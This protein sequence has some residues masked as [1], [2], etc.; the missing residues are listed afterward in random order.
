MDLEIRVYLVYSSYLLMLRKALIIQT[1]IRCMQDD[2]GIDVVSVLK[3]LSDPQKISILRELGKEEEGLSFSLTIGLILI[4]AESSQQAVKSGDDS[5]KGEDKK[6][7]RLSLEEL[8]QV[9]A[10]E[11]PDRNRRRKH[12][13][14][15]AQLG[16]PSVVKF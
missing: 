14:E 13:H 6:K 4:L 2:K 10:K 11:K 9:I 7:P 16:N 8:I 15:A 5:E 12:Q 3:L 1:V